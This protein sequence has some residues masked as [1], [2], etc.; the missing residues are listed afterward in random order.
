MLFFI[1]REYI[2]L[3]K[4]YNMILFP[5]V[6]FLLC[7]LLFVIAIGVDKNT[8]YKIG[9]AIIW[10]LCLLSNFLGGA[11]LFRIDYETG[12][13]HELLLGTYSIWQLIL[14]KM[15]AL[16]LFYY[17]PIIVSS[18]ILS[19]WFSVSWEQHMMNVFYLIAGAPAIV[20]L[21]SLGY[22]ITLG[23]KLSSILSFMTILPLLIPVLIF[24]TAHANDGFFTHVAIL[25]SLGLFAVFLTLMLGGEG[26]KNALQ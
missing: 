25:T 13:L 8:L 15:I 1:K 5:I 3:R 22:I 7:G 14:G 20:A 21:I 19:V 26:L 10:V 17:S 2:L 23:S 9:P 12:A 6:F 18:M 16:F 4:D 24:G 11:Q